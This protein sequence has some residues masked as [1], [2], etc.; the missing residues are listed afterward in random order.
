MTVMNETGP[1]ATTAPR[2]GQGERSDAGG[3]SAMSY[4]FVA[5]YTALVIA[6]GVLPALYAVFLAFTDSEGGFAGI[7]NFTKVVSDFRFLPAVAHVALYLVIWL[8]ALVVLVS[9]LAVV[10]HAVRVRWLS[11]TLRFVFYLPGALAGASSVM[12]W[13]FV[14]DPTASP[15][16]GLLRLLGF[17]SFVQ[18]IVP[19]NL[20]PVFAIIA[21][22]TGAGGWIVIMYGALNNISPDVIEAARIDGATAVQIARRI[23][24]PMLRKWISYMGIMSLAAGTQ[25]FVEPQLLSQASN[26]IVPNDYSLNQLAYQYAFQQNDFNGAAAISLL[27]LVIALALSAV[28]VTRGGLFEKD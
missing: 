28:F 7:A 23:Q 21:F 25:L 8:V 27:L 19:A 6:F 18:V 20:P 2:G 9:F 22:W 14:L 10:V 12:L 16:S 4:G 13:L 26:A 1:S 5:P 3:R 17:S 15:V 11:R 24:L